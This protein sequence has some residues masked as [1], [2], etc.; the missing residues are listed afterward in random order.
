MKDLSRPPA[1][2]IGFLLFF[3]KEI[4]NKSSAGGRRDFLN[5]SSFTVEGGRRQPVPALP[6]TTK[7]R[8][9]AKDII[10]PD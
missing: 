1:D 8:G 7:H 4:E 10:F 6:T 9:K 2:F 3:P 5:T